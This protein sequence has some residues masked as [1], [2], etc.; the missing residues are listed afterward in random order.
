M[1]ETYFIAL[2]AIIM[3]SFV[4]IIVFVAARTGWIMENQ[5]KIIKLLEAP[6]ESED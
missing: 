2:V 4:G 5:E 3:L 1:N 6:P